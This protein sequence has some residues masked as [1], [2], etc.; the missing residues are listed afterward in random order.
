M[1][2]QNFEPRCLN[3]KRQIAYGATGYI[4][5]C[6]WT[7]SPDNPDYQMFYDPLLH[8]DNNESIENIFESKTWQVFYHMLENA[9][10]KAPKLCHEM[11][12]NTKTN[13]NRDKIIID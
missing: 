7:E 4:T 6:C 1:S 13:P 9:P 11:C 5:P 10:S 3:N 8:I 2:K 12:S